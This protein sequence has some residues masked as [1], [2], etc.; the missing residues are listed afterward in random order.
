METFDR[1]FNKNFLYSLGFHFLFFLLSFAGGKLVSTIF[2]SSD[3]EIIHSA[4]R[5]DVIGMPKFTLQEL[6]KMEA[7]PVVEKLPQIVKGTKDEAKTENE[8]VIKKNDL[9]IQKE[10]KK[11]E[12]VSFL[13]LINDYSN[14]KIAVKADKKGSKE[15]VSS[16]QLDSLIIE[17]NKLSKGSALVGDYSD[18]QQSDF[19][20]YVQNIPGIIRPFWKLPSYLME[21]N[22]RCRIKIFLSSEGKLIKIELQES[23]GVSE[24]DVRAEQAVRDSIFPKPSEKVGTRLTSYGIILGFPI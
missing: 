6:K 1:N 21:K 17:G 10:T 16:S 7:Q 24:F 11:K 23:S 20:A 14:K 8:D 2:Q 13:N 19:S 18:V 3:V 5:V 15:S 12:R 22:L 4:V 9:I